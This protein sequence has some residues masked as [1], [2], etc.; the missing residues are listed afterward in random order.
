MKNADVLP[1]YPIKVEPHFND[2]KIRE[3]KP[4]LFKK[5]SFDKN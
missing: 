1:E 3:R 5:I 4:I 2:S